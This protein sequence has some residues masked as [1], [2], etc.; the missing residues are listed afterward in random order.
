[1]ELE[2]STYSVETLE[3]DKKFLLGNFIEFYDK[4][5]NWKK[6]LLELTLKY[7]KNSIYKKK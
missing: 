2:L 4:N 7:F 3:S 5:L 1:M 6:T